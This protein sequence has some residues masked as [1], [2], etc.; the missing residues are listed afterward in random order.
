MAKQPTKKTANKAVAKKTTTKPVA[1][2]KTAVK[3][4]AAKT[5]VTKKVAA[6]KPASKPVAP[7]APA[8]PKAKSKPSLTR[9]LVK[10][11]VGFGNELHL[12]GAGGGLSWD[13]GTTMENAS[14]DEWLW[15]GEVKSGEV[16]FKVLLNDTLW[17]VGD[18]CVVAAGASIVVEPVF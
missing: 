14:A 9:I 5:I 8:K 1:A 12:R 7:K 3:K 16:V 15:Q 6:P 17:S 4:V 10:A 18:D 11:D 13:Y 2:K